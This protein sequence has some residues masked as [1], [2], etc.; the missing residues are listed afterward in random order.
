MVLVTTKVM[1]QDVATVSLP[2]TA[3]IGYTAG[4]KVLTL[5]NPTAGTGFANA[6]KDD[7]YLNYTSIVDALLTN[8]IQVAL[9]LA[10]PNG[11]TLTITAVP[12]TGTGTPGTAATATFLGG[13]VITVQPVIT[14]IGSCNSGAGILG[15]KLIYTW[16]MDAGYTAKA[17]VSTNI[18]ATYTIVASV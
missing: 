3:V 11:T 17:V 12:T 6:V 8:K 7:S 2:A 13:G 1:A 15:A 5:Q 10:V 9:S 14:L 4:V 16:K 18:T